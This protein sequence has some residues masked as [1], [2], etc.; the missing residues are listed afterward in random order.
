MGAGVCPVTEAAGNVIRRRDIAGVSITEAVYDK[1]VSL[2]R[3]CHAHAYLTLVLEGAYNEKHSDREFTWNEGDLHLLPAGE[4]HE[5]QFPTPVRCLRL[6][7]ESRAVDRLGGEF[8]GLLSEPRKLTGPLAGWLAKRVLD[9]FRSSD[10]V[11]SL[12]MEGVVLELLAECGRS[13]EQESSSSAPAWL[14]R[15][16]EVLDE[17]YLSS[18]SLTDLANVGGVHPVHLSREFR[19]R[20]QVTIGE[21]A[22]KR[23][24]DRASELLS[25][26]DLSLSEIAQTCGFSDQSHFCALFKRYSGM[27]PAKFRDLAGRSVKPT[28]LALAGSGS[29]SR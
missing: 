25:N 8:E 18:P 20:Y 9:E 15:V 3:H 23:R 26:S 22:R 10:D 14:R 11:A 24:I 5:N 1:G 4:R 2:G 12:A 13:S 27:T 29:Q 7:F 21:Y 16:R 28:R 19:R 6:K 17:S